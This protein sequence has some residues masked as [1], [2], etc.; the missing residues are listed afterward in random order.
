MKKN[1]KVVM[2]SAIIA[3]VLL[4]GMV[5]C[6][7]APSSTEPVKIGVLASL[8]SWAGPDS[9]EVVAGVKFKLDEVG[10]EVAGRKIELIVE[11][12]FGDPTTGVDKA[13]KLVESDKVDVILGPFLSNVFYAVADYTKE[14]RTPMLGIEMNSIEA[15]Q[16]GG[17]NVLFHEGT[18]YGEGYYLGLYA[19]DVKGYRTA[20]FLYPDTF[21]CEQWK[22]GFVRA[23]GEERGGTCFEPQRVA[24]GT[25]DYSPYLTV[26]KKADVLFFWQQGQLV[27]P[28]L[29]QY[30]Q[31]GL[32][33]PLATPCMT[34][35]KDSHL[36]DIKADIEGG[37][38]MI[39]STT[40]V[41]AID[42]DTNKQFVDAFEK[43]C[44]Y[45]PDTVNEAAYTSTSM[46]LEAVKATGG[47][48]SHD[49]IINALHKVKAETPSGP[50]SYNSQ[51]LGIANLYIV[52]PAKIA[53]TYTWVPVYTYSEVLQ[54]WPAK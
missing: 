51:G 36:A 17:G 21:Y 48:T 11:D 34:V 10:Y 46:F 1:N 50:V 54:D 5:G 22:D 23:F 49:A 38:S 42:T 45:K 3:L 30:H 25:V 15:T 44:G 35:I 24:E 52:S 32:T 47:D 37:L 8:T 53:D 13:R 20:A 29:S 43:G 6:A 7:P 40:Y 26:M 39:G 33:M 16:T 41:W 4:L 12:D 9:Q 28:F 2:L 19:Y 31:Y 27:A 18:L 14:S